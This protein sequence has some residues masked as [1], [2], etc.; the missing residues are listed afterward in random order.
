[1]QHSKGF[2]LGFF[3]TFGKEALIKH[4]NGKCIMMDATAGVL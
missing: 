4:G 1:M 2:S 3:T